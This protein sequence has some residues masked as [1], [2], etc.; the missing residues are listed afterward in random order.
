MP[1]YYDGVIAW[2]V[3]QR[4]RRRPT[5]YSFS[6]ALPLHG[7]AYWTA[8]DAIERPGTIGT[9][10]A[11]IIGANRLRLATDNLTGVAVLPDPV[12]VDLARPLALEIEGQAIFEGVVAADRELRLTKQNGRWR[13]AEAPRRQRSLTAYR[14]HP[15]A[16]A[17]A[18]LTM[19]GIEAPLASWITDAM[20]LATGADLALY[21]RRSY[22]GLPLPA[23]T[24]DQVDLIQC[25]RPFEQYLVVAE[26]QGSDI[27]S[28]LEANIRDPDEGLEFLVQLSGASYTFDWDRPVGQRIVAVYTLDPE[29]RY[30]V[31]L[32]GHVPERGQ[33]RSM[34]LSG[35]REMLPYR[36]TDVPFRAALYA[37]AVRSGRI[38]AA[39]EGRVRAV[40]GWWGGP[41]LPVPRHHT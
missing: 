33:G 27:L 18:A 17:P 21:N 8:I 20:R 23:G 22:R 7:Q 14:T 25:S 16:A 30:R 37:H 11:Q 35:H 15:V 5:G 3:R 32:E 2:L 29:R 36:I 6:A 19:E 34:F 1:E 39:V 4:L 28:V 31:A 10:H 26:L 13:V 9:V 41:D 38:E 24:V 40:G 12:L